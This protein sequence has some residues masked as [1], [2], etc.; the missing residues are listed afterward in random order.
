LLDKVLDEQRDRWQKRDRVPVEEYLA[1][2]PALGED[3]EALIDLVYQEVLLRR[4]LGE[5]PSAQEY[6]SRFPTWSE[7]L[8]RQFAVDEA[9]QTADRDAMATRMGHSPLPDRGAEGARPAADASLPAIEGYE[10]LELLGRGGMGIVYKARDN[11][12]ARIVAIKMIA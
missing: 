2:Y 10:L 7:A 1:R 11:K 3:A 9:M 8:L 12:L 5:S 6:V 4:Q